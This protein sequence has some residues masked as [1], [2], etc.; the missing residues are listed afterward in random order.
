[1]LAHYIRCVYHC[2]GVFSSFFQVFLITGHDLPFSLVFS[3]FLAF[4]FKKSKNNSK[5]QVV[6]WVL[7]WIFESFC[8][9][10]HGF[11]VPAPPE[12]GAFSSPCRHRLIPSSFLRFASSSSPFLFYMHT[13]RQLPSQFY[14]SI[15]Y[16]KFS[17]LRKHS[18]N[19]LIVIEVL[20]SSDSHTSVD[21]PVDP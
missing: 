13:T 20:I 16:F 12:G 18:F 6:R 1:M 9:L 4:A 19:L 7:G 8:P 15:I 2:Q 11:A 17:I 21:L 3:R 5:I 10:S 14:K